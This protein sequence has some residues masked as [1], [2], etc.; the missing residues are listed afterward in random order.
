VNNIY[1]HYGSTVYDPSKFQ[2]IKNNLVWTKPEG[3]LWATPK[4]AKLG[5]KEWCDEF[6]NKACSDENSFLFTTVHD[7]NILQINTVEDLRGLPTLKN[8]IEIPGLDSPIEVP[9]DYICLDFERLMASGVDAIQVNISEDPSYSVD[10]LRK[11][12]DA[13]D[14]DT[15]LIMN[16]DIIVTL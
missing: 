10:R 11:K 7:A 2:A 3:G 14:C 6:G 8:Q 16:P 5:W 13:W 9:V 12:L 1:I 15:I 4:D